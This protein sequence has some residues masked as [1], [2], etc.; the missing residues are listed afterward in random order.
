MDIKDDVETGETVIVGFSGKVQNTTAGAR[1]EISFCTPEGDGTAGAVFESGVGCATQQPSGPQQSAPLS[2]AG[3]VQ[4]AGSSDAATGKG[5]ICIP[6]S[7]TLNKMAVMYFTNQ[8]STSGIS[9]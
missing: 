2:T 6:A 8:T 9:A 4:Q 1:S 5:A 3:V 7:S